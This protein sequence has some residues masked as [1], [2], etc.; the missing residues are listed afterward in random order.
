VISYL[1]Y[2]KKFLEIKKISKEKSL[3][4]IH[5]SPKGKGLLVEKVKYFK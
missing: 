3:T 1:E 2:I 4:T 5:P